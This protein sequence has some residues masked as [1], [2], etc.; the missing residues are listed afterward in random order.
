MLQEHLIHTKIR[1]K[2]SN[3]N[4]CHHFLSIPQEYYD[5]FFFYNQSDQLRSNLEIVTLSAE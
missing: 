4:F 1:K 2:K 3:L 5:V